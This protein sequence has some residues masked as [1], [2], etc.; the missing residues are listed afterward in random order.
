VQV[1]KLLKKV[2]IAIKRGDGL[3]LVL[4]D[5]SSRRLREAIAKAGDDAW[6]EF[7]GDQALIYVPESATPLDEWANQQGWVAP[8]KTGT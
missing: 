6:Y 3:S 2:K 1:P 4:T 7:E 5:A 8:A